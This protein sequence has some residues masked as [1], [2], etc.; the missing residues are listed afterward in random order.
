MST[1]YASLFDMLH[2]F[3]PL[4]E[5]GRELGQLIHSSS[6]LSGA[7]YPDDTKA[8]RALSE[9]M[10]RVCIEFGFRATARQ[11][12]GVLERSPPT[13]YDGLLEQITHLDVSLR[14]EMME[15]GLVRIPSERV[16]Y[17][18]QTDAF[19]PE[20]AAAFPA[21]K[22]D[23]ERAGTCYALEQEDACVHHLMLVL[24]RGLNALAGKLAVQFKYTNWEEISRNITTKLGA[25][26]R[27]DERQ[28][29]LDT[30]AQFGFLRVAYRNYAEHVR[31]DPYDMPKA[32]SIYTHVRD[33][34]GTLAKGGLTE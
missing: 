22:R 24:E 7:P 13:T 19:G 25:L 6:L 31:D 20:V 4:F 16:G 5:I 1:R 28:F 17:F 2:D 3:T 32:L 27:G 8:F 21:C 10:Q 29:Y 18:E 23:I 30:N 15:E 34:M 33:F 12:A 26:P 9:K 14:G 11:A